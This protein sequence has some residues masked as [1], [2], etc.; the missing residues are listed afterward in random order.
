MALEAGAG[1][2][3]LEARDLAC[4]LVLALETA[5]VEE[6]LVGLAGV[7]HE[8]VECAVAIDIA[9]GDAKGGRAAAWEAAA[10]REASG[11]TVDQAL[12]RLAAVAQRLV[13]V[14]ICVDVPIGLEIFF[15]LLAHRHQLF[16]VVA[17]RR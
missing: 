6:Q 13:D 3:E 12:I 7:A 5:R 1:G 14:T 8:Q 4:E 16:D 15:Q 17:W 11:T 9:Q 2:V 10:R